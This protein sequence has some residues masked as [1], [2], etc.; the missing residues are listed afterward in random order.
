M[1]VSGSVAADGLETAQA[2]AGVEEEWRFELRGA[3]GKGGDQAAVCEYGSELIGEQTRH[4]GD[5]EHAGWML[6]ACARD[7][8]G[9]FPEGV[10]GDERWPQVRRERRDPARLMSVRDAGRSRRIDSAQCH[11]TLSGR[12]RRRSRRSG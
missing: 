10:A 3:G 11:D 6:S 12:S 8:S 7:Q 9:E 5:C 4:D 2:G 1:V